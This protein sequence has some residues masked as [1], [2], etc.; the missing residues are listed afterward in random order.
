MVLLLKEGK[1]EETL[2][3]FLERVT[4]LCLFKEVD[5]FLWRIA[6]KSDRAG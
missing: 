2:V 3:N 4:L 5:G 1:E 6:T